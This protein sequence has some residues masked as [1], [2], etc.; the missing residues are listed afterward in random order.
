MGTVACPTTGHYG[1]T[2]GS[3]IVV[4]VYGRYREQ[5]PYRA[6]QDDM[7][8]EE[9]RRSMPMLPSRG[10]P[11]VF[12]DICPGYPS[13]H[14]LYYRPGIVEAREEVRNPTR[15]VHLDQLVPFRKPVGVCSQ[16]LICP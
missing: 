3:E 2:V 1:A 7:H 6:H 15:R 8:D 16:R 4:E 12:A 10:S 9:P 14:G 13:A 5:A 11:L